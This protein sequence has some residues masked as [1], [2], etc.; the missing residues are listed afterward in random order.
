MPYPKKYPFKAATSIEEVA[1]AAIIAAM[2][3]GAQS[4]AEILEA[5]E[6]ASYANNEIGGES[7]EKIV[8]LMFMTTN[9]S[10]YE[11]QE[12]EYKFPSGSGTFYE[13]MWINA[14]YFIKKVAEKILKEEGARVSRE[15]DLEDYPLR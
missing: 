2:D 4:D 1:A 13:A 5:I 11:Q 3:E 12:L 8:Q 9:G 10:T 7:P 15:P 14:T 6:E